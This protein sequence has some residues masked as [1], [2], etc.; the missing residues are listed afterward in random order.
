MAKECVAAYTNNADMYPAFINV[1]KLD[2]GEFSVTVRGEGNGGLDMGE[3]VM[4]AA[5]FKVFMQTLVEN[6]NVQ[7]I[8]E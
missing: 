6:V 4:S 1:T 8:Q 7:E 2:S 3:I 5:A